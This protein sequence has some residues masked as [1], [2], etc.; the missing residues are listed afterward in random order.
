MSSFFYHNEPHILTGAFGHVASR[1][2]QRGQRARVQSADC[3]ALASHSSVTTGIP[4]LRASTVFSWKADVT[5]SSDT[6]PET[7]RFFWP[8]LVDSKNLR[9]ERVG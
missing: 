1:I 4:C 6:S 2:H 8:I 9:L 3:V 5:T 7:G